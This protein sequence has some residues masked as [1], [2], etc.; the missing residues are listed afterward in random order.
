MARQ[1]RGGGF[2]PPELRGT[3][4]TLVRTTLAQVG[5]LR[6][7]LE[8]GARD[9]A[10]SG[11]AR[12][13]EALS[14]RRRSAARNDALA[15]L[16]EIVLELIRQGEIDLGELPETRDVVAQLDELDAT[17]A[18]EHDEDIAPPPVRKRFDSR[19][20][21][22]HDDKD[23]GTVSSRTWSPP[24]PKPITASRKP[25]AT[26]P[27]RSSAVRVWRPPADSIDDAPPAAAADRSRAK[28]PPRKDPT[29]KGGISFDDDD[30]LAD[31]M[32]PDDVPPKPRSDG[33][34]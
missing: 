8:R 21:D 5:P 4:G 24:S 9:V 12:L 1:R 22:Q 31:Y 7:A 17:H 28:P 18:D 32:H 29:R 13:D 6:E 27:D 34:S 14:G 11:R 2:R 3:L 16:G 15:E 10:S 19:R 30:D 26:R 23:D 33:D 20:R 25:P